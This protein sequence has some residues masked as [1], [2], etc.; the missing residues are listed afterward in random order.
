MV[1]VFFGIPY[2][3][4]PIGDNRWCP[5]KPAKP[6]APSVLQATKPPPGC[7]Q[8]CDLPPY[9]CPDSVS[10]DCL[11]LTVFTPLTA[12]NGSKFPVMMFIHGGNFITGSGYTELTDGR[13]MSNYTNTVTV[14][15]NYRLGAFGFLVAGTKSDAAIGNYGIMDQRAAMDWIQSNI[16]AFGGDPDKVTIFGQSAGSQSVAIHLATDK[17]KHLFHRAIIESFPYSVPFK[18]PWEAVILGNDLADDLNCTHGDMKCLRSA[19]PESVYAAQGQS[20]G[21]I[22]N[23]LRLLEE[24]EPW[25]PVVDG[26]DITKQSVDSFMKGEYQDKPIMMGTTS[27]EARIYIFGAFPDPAN[28]IQVYEFVLAVFP[29]HFFKV[30]E[31][32]PPGPPGSDQREPLSTAAHHFVFACP[33]RAALRGVARHG[34]NKVWMYLYDHVM[35]FHKAWGPSWE[36]MCTTHVC[37]GA[38]LPF[39]FHTATNGGYNYT[40]DEL[41]LTDTMLYYW[42]N[43]AH[44][45]NP[46]NGQT[47]KSATSYVHNR[48]QNWPEYSNSSNWSYMHFTTP[49]RVDKDYLSKKCDFWDTLDVYSRK[50]RILHKSCQ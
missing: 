21:V 5:P 27:D 46:N 16:E 44:T 9:T 25:G 18:T 12:V 8:H 10:E 17:S 7:Y 1:K 33:T 39:V 42:T 4:P 36:S 31:E 50:Y 43:F 24:F 29:T 30:I 40:P 47:K 11:Y 38:E 20:G 14:F 22:I 15:I 23:P 45:G 19:S 48:L 37:H 28:I 34:N 49:S 35:S 6:W 26:K 41:V 13:F 2:A 32:Y 3:S